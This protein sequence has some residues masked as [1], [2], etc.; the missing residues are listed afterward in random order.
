MQFITNLDWDYPLLCLIADDVGDDLWMAE[1]D[2]FCSTCGT[3]LFL[4]SSEFLVIPLCID[5]AKL[6][7]AHDMKC[8]KQ[9][10]LYNTYCV[11][12]NKFKI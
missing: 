1:G 11:V 4:T 3:N 5:G 8:S 6:F 7:R 12:N 10:V 9:Y 2:V